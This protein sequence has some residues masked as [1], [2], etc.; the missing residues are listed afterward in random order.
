MYLFYERPGTTPL[1]KSF[2]EQTYEI[3]MTLFSLSFAPEPKN[4]PQ[5]R[6][7]GGGSLATL[8]R[9]RKRF[10]KG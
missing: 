10:P 8:N 3:T 4:Q 5:I 1:P 7:H 9:A 2:P 6:G